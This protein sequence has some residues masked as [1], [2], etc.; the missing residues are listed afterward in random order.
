MATPAWIPD[1][2]DLI[3]ELPEN[4]KG[5]TVD[6]ADDRVAH[7]AALLEFAPSTVRQVALA[8]GLIS[9][10]AR[11]ELQALQLRRAGHIETPGADAV[12]E[13]ARNDL[14]AYNAIQVTVGDEDTEQVAYFGTTPW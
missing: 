2:A 12:V 11:G 4:G 5:V 8:K 14:A 6:E 9:L 7:W 1:G 10:G 13:M 3:T